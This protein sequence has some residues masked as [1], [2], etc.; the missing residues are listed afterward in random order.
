MI[1]T[2]SL[3][4][5]LFA[6]ALGLAVFVYATVGLPAA[7]WLYPLAASGLFAIVLIA[8]VVKIRGLGLTSVPVLSCIEMPLVAQLSFFHLIYLLPAL[9]PRA[10]VS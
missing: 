6:I 9:A 4:R 7:G 3:Q 10:F 8:A 2:S 1:F 5:V